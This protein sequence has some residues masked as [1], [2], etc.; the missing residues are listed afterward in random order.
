VNRGRFNRLRSFATHTPVLA[1]RVT[2]RIH[3]QSLHYR[4]YFA[5]LD[6][7][8]RSPFKLILLRL[9]PPH[10][11]SFTVSSKLK[12]HVHLSLF[13]HT[14]VSSQTSS[15]GSHFS[16]HCHLGLHFHCCHSSSPNSFSPV[17]VTRPP[18]FNF[19]HYISFTVH[20]TIII[21]IIINIIIE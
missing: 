15:P 18:A 21:P 17:S 7:I 19:I 14:S 8:N 2:S 4:K 3:I 13:A 20:G 16:S 9:P 12:S 10:V 11:V 6:C 1:A 5:S